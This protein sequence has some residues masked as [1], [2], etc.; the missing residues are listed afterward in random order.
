MEFHILIG[1]AGHLRLPLRANYYHT[2]TASARH[3]AAIALEQHISKAQTHM[4]Y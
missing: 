2:T 1:I 3:H 4:S